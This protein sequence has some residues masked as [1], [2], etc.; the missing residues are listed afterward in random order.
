MRECKF[1]CIRGIQRPQYRRRFGD[2][3]RAQ[4]GKC[5]EPD[6]GDRTEEPADKTGAVFL[7][8]EQRHQDARG[9][10]QHHLLQT[11]RSQTQSLDRRQ[12]RDRR[13]DDG[14]AIEQ[15]GCEHAGCDHRARPGRGLAGQTMRQRGKRQYASLAFVVVLEHEPDILDGDDERQRPEQ[16]RQR[17]Q[18][19]VLGCR[20]AVRSG[21]RFLECI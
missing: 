6:A 10:R 9:N 5:E 16:H 15:R 7:Y 14:V 1:H 12:D 18:H 3:D 21:E 17:G 4:D 19:V 20:Q 13:R 2:A 11:W 8:R